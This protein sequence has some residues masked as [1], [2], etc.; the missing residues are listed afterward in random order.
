MKALLVL[1][2]LLLASLHLH[3]W[4]GD[5]RGA[6]PGPLVAPVTEGPRPILLEESTLRS[7]VREE[8]ARALGASGVTEVDVAA[9]SA[10]VNQGVRQGLAEARIRET[11]A[12][13]YVAGYYDAL[14]EIEQIEAA[15]VQAE[16]AYE[17][18]RRNLRQIASA[19]QQYMLAEGVPEVFFENLI[20]PGGYLSQ[21]PSVAGEDYRA[22]FPID[23]R[24]NRLAIRTPDGAVVEY[25]F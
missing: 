8:V 14:H 5:R 16:Q 2:L 1:A 22:V 7:L 10:S 13:E 19:A 12:T 9:I 15:R 3:L 17:A 21:V 25:R 24:T 20:G 11:I 23:S 18:I 6:E 4:L